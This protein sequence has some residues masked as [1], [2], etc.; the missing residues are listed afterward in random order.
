MD[1][2][3]SNRSPQ[4]EIHIQAFWLKAL[5]CSTLMAAGARAEPLEAPTGAIADIVVTGTLI[6]SDGSHGQPLLT[7]TADDLLQKGY[8]SVYDA[9]SHSVVANGNV[10]G[11]QDGGFTRGARAVSLFGL[12][13]IYTK[14]LV[15]GQPVS[16]YPALYNGDSSIADIGGIP[17]SLVER[18]DILPGGQSSLYGSDAIA[19]VINVILKRHMDG[20][21]LDLARHGT[22]AGGGSSNRIA[23]ANSWSVNRLDVVASLSYQ[24]TDP[25]WGYQRGLTSENYAFGSTPQLANPGWVVE[26]LAGPTG[27]GLDGFYLKD[28]M[29]CGGL[30]SQFAGTTGSFT[31]PGLGSYCGTTR[32][33]FS[34]IANGDELESGYLHATFAVTPSVNIYFGGLASK[35]AV[36]FSGGALGF[37]SLQLSGPTRVIYEPSVN[38][39]VV[40]GRQFSPEEAG[41]LDSTLSAA[42]VGHL[43]LTAGVSAL[44]SHHWN[45]DASVNLDSQSLTERSHVLRT[46]AVAGYL[47]GIL[48]APSG[49]DP[50]GLGLTAFT[51]N[52]AAFY[53]PLTSQ[54][55]HGLTG[56]AVTDSGTREFT[57]RAQLTNSAAFHLQGGDVGVALVGE[58]GSEG[59][60][61]HPD[62]GILD[63]QFLGYTSVGDSSAQRTREAVTGEIRVPLSRVTTVDASARFDR[64]SFGSTTF[65]KPTY[66]LGIEYSPF[67]N[68]VIHGR[69]GQAFR[70]PSLA[71]EGQGLSGSYTAVTDYYQCALAGYPISNTAGC[72]FP[73]GGQVKVFEVG[74]PNL[75]ATSAKT[76]EFG[77]RWMPTMSLTADLNFRNWKIRDEVHEVSAFGV[78][79]TEAQCRLGM[80]ALQ[81]PICQSALSEV[82]R[83]VTTGNL[84]SIILP[85]I[86]VSR[87]EV[88]ALTASVSYFHSLGSSG[89]VRA[90][91]SWN[92]SLKHVRQT[93]ANGPAA[94]LLAL[95]FLHQE[96]KTTT[97]GS[98][99]W[100]KES[101]SNSLAFFRTGK[102]P[103]YA[104]AQSVKGY[105]EVGA[106]DLAPW[107]IFNLTSTYRFSP[108]MQFSAGVQNV[109]NAMP[110]TD[111]SYPGT[112]AVPYD[113]MAYSVYGR[114]YE[115]AFR[116]GL[117]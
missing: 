62:R 12:S 59:W 26:G 29:N 101:W 97:N 67:S 13:P 7:I 43:H 47:S 74:N 71:D 77:V 27:N 90:D 78:L 49:Q 108:R 112:T 57:L 48:G 18:I 25:I 111:H 16:D 75:K 22:S 116:Y 36:A 68:L 80:I 11:A 83:S 54:Q 117:R 4:S 9:I 10:I 86:N 44:L 19:G 94:D 50:Y 114:M 58:F 30:S 95:P 84:V 17:M 14:Y 105:A 79:E 21:Q 41:S 93:F 82:T 70:A 85:K 61:Y 73:F 2:R 15:D 37:S 32:A 99:T 52:Y 53:T 35:E 89:D 24:K 28:P 69:A 91:L 45:L 81:S 104:A 115:V 5:I 109:F 33:G 113:S 106:A 110:P 39:A 100:I 31:V 34:T 72:P 3:I 23:L 88:S 8:T 20:P 65:Q 40:F 51:P 6:P 98:L 38:D 103:N 46:S 96:F 107:W 55:Y 76:T 66:S 87:E 63:G 42:N 102:S 60:S 92:D 64:Y 56:F 1:V